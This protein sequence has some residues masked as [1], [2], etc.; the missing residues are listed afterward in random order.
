VK[1]DA[2]DEAAR[3]KI[4]AELKHPLAAG[5]KQQ[6]FHEQVPSPAGGWPKGDY[7]VRSELIVNDRVVNERPAERFAMGVIHWRETDVELTASEVQDAGYAV[8]SGV[9]VERG[10]ALLVTATGTVAPGPVAFYRELLAEPSLGAPRPAKPEGIKWWQD[11][12]ALHRYGLV[13]VK[14][15]YAALLMRVGIVGW[16]AYN[17]PLPPHTMPLAGKL[18]LSINSILQSRPPGGVLRTVP[19]DD[20]TYWQP[21]SGS[22]KVTIL[23]GTFDFPEK[24]SLEM[25]E[26]LLRRFE[27]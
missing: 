7:S 22:F 12:P 13:D 24:L 15:N 19:R 4:V 25:C 3:D 1:K 5:S 2:K 11:R 14:S 16:V 8:D 18:E 10:D 9:T 26:F 27:F 23:H 17:D 20:R 6:R 21:D